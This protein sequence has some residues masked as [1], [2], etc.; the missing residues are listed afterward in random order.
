MSLMDRFGGGGGMCRGNVRIRGQL[1]GIVLE[2]VGS[3][4]DEY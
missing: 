1:R 3:P 4:T 2:A